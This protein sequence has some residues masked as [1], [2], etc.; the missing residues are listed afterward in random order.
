MIEQMRTEVKINDLPESKR[1]VTLLIDEMKI[2]EDL[3]FDKH[4]CTMIGFVRLGSIND[5]LLRVEQGIDETNPPFADRPCSRNYGERIVFQIRI[6]SGTLSLKRMYW[7]NVV[8][9]RLG[10]NTCS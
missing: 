9:N 5:Q 8:S 4:S 6:S 7:T 1:Y 10:C 2:K 3:V